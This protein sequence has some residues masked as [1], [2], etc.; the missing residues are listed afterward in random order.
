MALATMGTCTGGSIRIPAAACGTVGLKPTFGEIP[1]DG[2]VPLSRTFDHAGPLTQTAG[3]AA[4]VYA[5]LLGE[6]RRTP[7]VPMPV[8]GLRIGVLR[9]YFCDLLDDD[10]RAF[11]EGAL[12]RL[13]QAG[14]TIDDVDI[15]H[16]T[17]IAT[18]YLHIQLAD[19]SA[20]HATMIDAMPESHEERPAAPGNGRTCLPRLRARP[21]RPRR[22]PP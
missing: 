3:D 10:V 5:A 1:T 21:R 22:A 16:A 17:D 9:K 13:R 18:V 19:A 7:P 14:A 6:P 15:R 2:V 12:D 4:L 11:L 8:R 20:Y